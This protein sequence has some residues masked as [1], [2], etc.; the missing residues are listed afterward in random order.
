[1][2]SLNVLRAQPWVSLTVVVPKPQKPNEIRICV[3]MRSLNKAIIR[4]LSK[5]SE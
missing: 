4:N 1:M 5:E 2:A 3:D